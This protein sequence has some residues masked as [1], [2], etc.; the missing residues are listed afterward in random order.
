MGNI[1][2]IGLHRCATLYAWRVSCPIQRAAAELSSLGLLL[3]CY[4][5]VPLWHRAAKAAAFPF[6][7]PIFTA[8]NLLLRC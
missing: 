2:L 6:L 3:C 5:L 7:I 1:L 4:L 8:S